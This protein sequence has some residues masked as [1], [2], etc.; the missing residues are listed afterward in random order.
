MHPYTQK[1]MS[2]G[3]DSLSGALVK[4]LHFQRIFIS[5][6]FDFKTRLRSVDR[7][8]HNNGGCNAREERST[9][10][11]ASV[12]W[13]RSFKPGIIVPQNPHQ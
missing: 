10:L 12:Y 4:I 3:D 8:K 1:L 13:Q 6:A 11:R 5:P 2:R 7:L 9:L